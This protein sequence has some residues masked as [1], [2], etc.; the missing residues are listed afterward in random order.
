MFVQLMCARCSQSR[1]T[2]SSRLT[3]TTVT[4]VTRTMKIT[5]FFALKKMENHLRFVARVHDASSRLINTAL[6]GVWWR[7]VLLVQA[8]GW[9][10]PRA[11]EASNSDTWQKF[12]DLLGPVQTCSDQFGAAPQPTPAGT[13]PHLY[14]TK[15]EPYPSTD[16]FPLS[17]PSSFLYKTDTQLIIPST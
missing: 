1:M 9:G 13:E 6:H 12:L 8:A 11:E 15:A 17:F 16:R 4:T 7:Q 2:V 14:C 10:A 5:I 3:T